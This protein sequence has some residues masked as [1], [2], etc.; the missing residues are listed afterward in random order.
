[1][2]G[3]TPNAQALIHRGA[4]LQRPVGYVADP[5]VDRHPFVEPV[6]IDHR[7]PYA[8]DGRIDRD[9]RL[10]G[11]HG[12]GTL[13]VRRGG[14]RLLASRVARDAFARPVS[15]PLAARRLPT[16]ATRV[17]SPHRGSADERR[18]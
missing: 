10:D 1:M 15:V 2:E 4:V 14:R 5:S 11:T 9:L 8:I 13:P 7:L 12:P 16:H 6:G 18:G 17:R 3:Q